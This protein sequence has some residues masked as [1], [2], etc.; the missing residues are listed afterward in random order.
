M[1]RRRA[2]N[3][4]ERPHRLHRGRSVTL[5]RN[6]WRRSLA[7]AS[8]LIRRAAYARVAR[9]E[10][11]GVEGVVPEV[12]IADDSQSLRLLITATLASDDY[13]VIEAAD[14]DQAYSLLQRHEPAVA[15]LDVQMPGRS[16]LELAR[17]IRSDPR[18]RET[19][20]ILL[21]SMARDA[22]VAAGYAA[23][24]DLYLTK[25]FSPIELLTVVEQAIRSAG[26]TVGSRH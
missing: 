15:V 24:A 18:L 11:S 25:P 12:L 16:G 7:A 2:D 8:R 3:Q 23:G 1:S 9:R 4:V 22:D 13:T 17:A 10:A 26:T 19:R 5:P 6:A 14:G 20:V 21:T